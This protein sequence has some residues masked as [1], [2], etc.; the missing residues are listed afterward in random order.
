VSRHAPLEAVREALAGRPAWLVGGAVRDEL[1]G[2]ATDDVDVAVEGDPREPARALARATG[3]AAFRLSG[4]YGAWRVVGPGHT[5]HV[6]LV[7]LREDGIEG[8]LGKRDFSINAMAEPL[9]GG[10]LLDPFGGQADLRLGRLR[11]VT[12][13]ALA[14]D[15]L[16][17]L[18]AIRQA[19]ELGL[20]IDRATAEE[21][22]RRA[23]ELDRVAPERIFGELKRVV[24]AQDVRRG[25]ELM[26]AHGITAAVLPEILPLHGVGQSDFHHADVHDHTL[27][28]LDSVLVIEDDPAYAG[29]PD[30]ADEIRALLAEPLADEL[31]RGGALR[32]AALLHDVA[33]PETRTEG[34]GRVGF[35][36][37][38]ERGAEVAAAVLRRL[39][40]SERLVEH[41]AGLI[42]NH[43]RVGFLVH[44]RP[45][46]RREIWR[47]LRATEPRSA[48]VTLLTVAD[49]LATRGRNADAA[50]EGHLDVAR[51]MLDAAFAERAAPRQ[52]PIVR[53]DELA[54]ELGMAPGPE[55]GTLLAQLA[56]DR[57]AGE[58]STREDALERARELR[59]S[60]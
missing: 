37:H 15:P 53:G 38:D 25:L 33:K 51:T 8:D 60:G 27:E 52:A 12:P 35:P 50:I 3:G 46:G 45:L 48:D 44:A 34:G 43:L 56:E 6:D 19:V 36:G 11:M 20:E 31:D 4:E 57:Y 47:Y 24:G 28:V 41:V 54:R 30:Q 17:T 23:P 58:I 9:D 49:R 16:R 39:R 29:L 26:E 18:R 40:A 13:E 7:A 22:A 10:R 14:E 5:W 1:L 2:R 42:R 32:W 59:G 55:L 21:I